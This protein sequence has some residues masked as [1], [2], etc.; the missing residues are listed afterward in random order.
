MN[1]TSQNSTKVTLF[2]SYFFCLLLAA[3]ML[4]IYPIITWF[5]GS[6][7]MNEVLLI[8]TAFYV[9][10]P[11]AIVALRSII[12]LLH[13]ILKEQI[14]IPENVRYMRVLSWCCAFVSA[15]SFIAGLVLILPMTSNIL[16]SFIYIAFFIFSFGGL[17]MMLILRVLKNV[18]AKATE[19]KNENELTI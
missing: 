8:I 5:L 14:F 18:M 19:L 9:C 10:C 11:A 1:Y 17:F 3:L 6:K 13:N 2:I 4:F 15:V 16:T 12:S 7:R